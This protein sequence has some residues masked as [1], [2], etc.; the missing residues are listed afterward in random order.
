MFHEGRE[1]TR[2]RIGR[3]GGSTGERE[4]A[5]EREKGE[6]E[7]VSKSRQGNGVNEFMQT[8]RKRE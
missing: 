6:R 7:G 3:E 5:R 8:Q 2:K 4:G 1:G